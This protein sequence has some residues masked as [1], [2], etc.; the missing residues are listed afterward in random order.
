[1]IQFSRLKLSGF[2]SFVDSTELVIAAG[3]TGVV[4]PNGCGK[5]NLIEAL[6]WV[7][8]E[9]S[10]RQM[11][12]G[13][14]DDVIFGGT[15]SRPARNV[16]E[17][18]VT[19]DNA[20]GTAPAQYHDV[21][22]LEVVRRIERG[23]GSAYRINGTER[24]ARD[25][26]LLFADAA[27]GARSSGLV[28][29]G[30]IGAIIN[31]KP[32]DRRS[33][34]EEAAGISGLYSRRHEAEN[35]L[36]SA[37]TNLE[38]LDDVLATLDEQ[39]KGLQKQAKQAARY[40][41][42]SDQIRVIEAQLL[43]LAWLEALATIDAARRAHKDSVFQ[44]EEATE[45]AAVAATLQADTAAGL[46]DLRRADA[47]AAGGLQRLLVERE[48]LD[49]EEGRIA[50]IRRDLDQRMAQA[51]SDLQRE[52][53]R[54]VDAEQAV[55]RLAAEREAIV[56]AAEGESE[57]RVEA[58]AIMDSAVQGVTEIEKDLG[59]VMEEVAAADAERAA[60]LRRHAEGETR[61]DRLKERLVAAESQREAAEADGVE[62]SDLT[63]A[64]MELE[65]A[66]EYLEES[67]VEAEDADRRRV[68]AQAARESAR[69]AFQ[70]AS[71]ARSRVKA[72]A[73]A[74]VAVLAQHKAS[75][76][77]PALDAVSATSGYE[78]ALAAA[79]GDDL[80][81]SLDKAAPLHWSDLPPVADAPPLPAGAEALARYVTAPSPLARRLAQ[82]GVVADAAAADALRPLLA[83]GQRLVTR[84]GDLFRWDGYTARAG[85]PNPMALRLA[86]RNR[87]RELQARLED[88]ELGMEEAEGRVQTATAAVETATEDERRAKEAV[89]RAEGET[90]KA[91][92]VHA[93]LAQ[94]FA[95]A[96][97][98]LA[99]LTDQCEAARANL[100]EAEG[101]LMMARE[102]VA[103][104]PESE[105]GKGKL[106]ILRADLAER[107]SVLVEARSALDRIIRES[108]DRKRRLE[109]LDN[110]AESWRRRAE[111]ARVTVEELEFRRESVMMEIERLAEMPDTIARRRDELLDRIQTAE[112]ARRAAADALIAAEHLQA[113]ADRRAR[114]TEA[115]LQTAREEQIRREAAVTAADQTCRVV[116]GRIAERLDMTP[117]NLREV[118][119][120]TEG[121]H[122]DRDD[123]QRR[124]DRLSR[125]RDAMGAVN[126]RAEQEVTELEERLVGM[127]AEKD[128]LVQAI[129]RLRQGIGE[130]NRE[131]RERLLAS[132]E[133]VDRHFRDLFVQ[134]FGGGRAHLALTESA[135]PLQAGLEIMASPPGK[136]LQQLS[137]LSGGEQALTALALLFAVFMT[138][139]API[140]VLDEVD[141]PLDDANVDRFCSLVEN[142]AKTTGTRFLIV[143]HHRM[144]MARMDRLY[145]VT[146]AERGVSQLVSVDLAQAEVIVETVLAG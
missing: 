4:G 45:L 70:A 44:V 6:R 78:P 107:R 74:L 131:G 128:D 119:C 79:L 88:S 49:A 33:L 69:D 35:K 22:E 43:Y 48:Q 39:L 116:A 93:R 122:P 46:P 133:A 11:R 63:G 3:M 140:C 32:A 99:A 61:R 105:A 66:L 38:R 142:I 21:P 137:L 84:D 9:T 1:L 68:H 89:K 139:P 16:C 92:D 60:A 138:N 117:E 41:T 100:E 65:S 12:G 123:M 37:E 64:E 126:L 13:E 31:A 55:A 130:L 20:E 113:E 75:G 77:A 103:A 72:E 146:M 135:D 104:F 76:H 101:E 17:V 53:A 134:L 15:S 114:A 67:R 57:A 51:A 47:E 143:T 95:A 108:G 42:L 127:R 98:R 102:A 18:T 145:G 19:L 112:A 34:L 80:N 62:R 2:K 94:R 7:M 29:Q 5:S 83:T 24:R 10:A 86:Q 82:V 50:G 120:L 30:K 58:D 90:A 27:T 111:A 121:E 85:A 14:M 59:R 124:H 73:D 54:A 56:D 25:V 97:S 81:A 132:F 36:K 125:E 71:A 26:Q 106:A 52:H 87:L 28:S 110:D 91:R 23:Q 129:A 8:G 109:S 40:R 96:E 115:A 141:A 144:S 118:A 136:R